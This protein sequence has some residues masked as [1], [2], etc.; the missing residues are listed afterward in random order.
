MPDD[1]YLAFKLLM[2]KIPEGKIEDQA[3]SSTVET[4]LIKIWPLLGGAGEERMYAAKLRGR[5]ENIEWTPPDIDLCDRAAWRGGHGVD[6]SGT[7]SLGS[8][9]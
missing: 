6:Q 4:A 3:V 2:S 5:M 8:E 7:S 1:H 9:C